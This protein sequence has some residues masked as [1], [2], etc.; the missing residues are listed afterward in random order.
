MGTQECCLEPLDPRLRG[1]DT[2][3]LRTMNSE[4]RT[5]AASSSDISL[6]HA[7]AEMGIQE[8]ARKNLGLSLIN[9]RSFSLLPEAS[10]MTTLNLRIRHRVSF[11][12]ILAVRHTV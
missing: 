4:R 8:S 11:P 10:R 9:G 5:G 7:N 2:F 12:G 1:D 6:N 3:E